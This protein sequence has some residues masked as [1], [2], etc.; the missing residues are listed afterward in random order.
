MVAG[1][2][3]SVTARDRVR[4]ALV[5][6]PHEPTL[7]PRV[8]YTA[9]S[10]AKRYAV[11]VVAVVQES[12]ARP[13]ENWPDAAYPT[14]RLPYRKHGVLKMCHAFLVLWV[15]RVLKH[16]WLA[17]KISSAIA[18][19]LL[20]LLC[21]LAMPAIALVIG[22]ELLLLP[23]VLLTEERLLLFPLSLRALRKVGRTA[24]RILGLQL[25]HTVDPFSV[26]RGLRVTL[27]MLRFTFCCNYLFWRYVVESTQ[28]PDVVYCHDLYSLQAGLILKRR[29]AT[30]VIYDSH[31]Y[32]PYQYQV[33]FYAP[34]IRFYESVL[35]R[36]VDVY[37]TVSPQLAEEL[38]RTYRV[39]RVYT[40]PN[41]EP[42]PRT[43][44][45]EK[46][47]AMSLL[48]EGRLRLLY[49]GTFGEGR[50]LEEVLREWGQVD[51]TKIALF[52]RGPRNMWLERVEALAEELGLLGKS[53]YVLPA[54]LEKDLIGAAQEADIGLIPY[55]GE[56]LSY[57][58]AGP[59]KLSQ[60]LHAGLAILGNR[61]PYV[62]EIIREGQC[63]LCYDV[64]KKGSLAEAVTT[65][66][67]DRAMVERFK[68][69]SLAFS[70]SEY[71]WE[72]YEPTLLKLVSGV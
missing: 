40:I 34:V 64:R 72:R 43:R 62:D 55:K 25:P 67:A 48:A 35:L 53:V 39:G 16:R 54:V 27:R 21:G 12:E 11:T 56:E 60:Y 5:L 1:D 65:L 46:T 19:A 28:R 10:L 66:V 7:D 9:E 3:L 69:N 50:G 63:G 37:I 13:K 20:V 32:Y 14:V 17:G 24:E 47:S 6:V 71:N 15:E 44:T 18:T 57:R 49:Q 41:V 31:E 33:W 70:Q 61:L 58:F 4:Q 36:D 38:S 2:Q 30:R 8:H 51:G 23:A 59:N 45:E 42:C 22:L 68:K 29:S 52:L 26:S